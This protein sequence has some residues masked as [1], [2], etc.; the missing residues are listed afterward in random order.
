LR[1]AVVIGSLIAGAGSASAP[2]QH[3]V[4]RSARIDHSFDDTWSA[5]IDVFADHSWAIDKVD[6]ASG[7]ITTDWMSLGLDG[8]TYADCG[9]A[10][11][12]DKSPTQVR[13]DVRVKPDGDAASIT[14]NTTFRQAR[15]IADAHG[16]VD[17]S[18]RGSVEALIRREVASASA[19]SPERAPKVQHNAL[20]PLPVAAA[21]RGGFAS[22]ERI[23]I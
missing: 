17:C 21:P 20:P 8:D 5:L 4:K 2:A 10:P 12:A 3:N 15:S 9:S 1:G 23:D 7:L 13:F 14:I 19:G 18:S 22:A 11:L 6:K 16:V